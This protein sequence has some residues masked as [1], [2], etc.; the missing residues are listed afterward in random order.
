M[1]NTL[2]NNSGILKKKSK[3]F[4]YRVVSYFSFL[5]IPVLTPK[6]LELHPGL[7]A[8]LMT[9]YIGFIMSQW[10][11]LGKEIDHRLKIYFRV[12]SSIDRIVYRLFLGMFFFIILFNLVN[13]LDPKWINNSFWIIWGIMGLFYSWPTRGKIIHESVSSNFGEFR[14]LDRFEKTLLALIVLM[15]IF[16]FPDLP[17]LVNVDTL[18]LYFD[19]MEQVSNSYWNFLVVNF[20]PFKSYPTLFRLGWSLHFYL[21]HMGLFLLVFYAF[22][23]F[24]V[25]RRLSLLGVF[26]VVSAWSYSKTLTHNNE[27]ILLTTYSLLWIWTMLWATKSSTYRAGLFLGLVSYWGSLLNLS[28]SILLFFQLGLLYF[29]F[30]RDRTF[31]FKRQLLKYAL[32]GSILTVVHFLNHTD[33]LYPI[34]GLDLAFWDSMKMEFSRKAFYILGIAGVFFFAHKISRESK[35]VSGPIRISY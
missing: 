5:L 18:R 11:L 13:L 19:P 24:F 29:V 6:G 32:F 28:Y 10:F 31:W 15:F 8:L 35:K 25:S 14:F 30:L 26:A 1:E 23:R 3:F 7:Q 17:P 12:N 20:Y 9:F 21:I 34:H 4:L 33:S 2:E 22:L 27:Y 16:S